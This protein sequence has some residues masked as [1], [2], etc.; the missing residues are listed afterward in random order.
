MRRLLAGIALAW[1]AAAAQAVEIPEEA[2][3]RNKGGYCA[4]AS[5]DTMARV[6]R[7][8][9]LVGILEQRRAKL[10]TAMDAGYDWLIEAELKDRGVRYELRKF[11]SR[12]TSLLEQHAESHG[13]MVSLLAGNSYSRMCHAIVVTKYDAEHVEFYD[14][15]NPVR[16]GKPKTWKC[17]RSWFD[18][19]WTGASVVVFGEQAPLGFLDEQDPSPQSVAAPLANVR[20][21]DGD[22][23][24]ADI[25][26][27]FGVTFRGRTIRAAGYDAWELSRA[28]RTVNV[29][30]VEV[31]R[32]KLARAALE[33]LLDGG[34]LLAE[35]TGKQDSYGR[36]LARLWVRTDGGRWID[37]AEYMRSE[38]HTREP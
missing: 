9:R 17:G 12:D 16:D 2:R 32:G 27:P 30:P 19:W 8:P 34:H 35:D 20:V 11:G 1:V 38:A 26:L 23:V 22:T 18:R 10:R 4:W 5:L 36:L 21:I 28:R 24:V 15:D 6:N 37:V 13:V 25:R 29:T 31:E 33:G 7:I 3:V 14:S